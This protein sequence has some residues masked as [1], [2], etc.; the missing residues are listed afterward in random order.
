MEQSNGQV[1]PEDEITLKE[2]IL[3]VKEFYEEVIHYWWIIALC[4]VFTLGYF[5]FLAFT[6]PVKYE[7][8][9]TFMLNDE[10]G[11]GA[12]AGLLG[13]FGFGGSSG[14]SIN[15]EKMVELAQSRV[16]LNEVIFDEITIENRN[17]YLAN[18]IIRV[19]DLH[20]KWGKSENEKM[21]N[22]LFTHDDISAFDRTEG[23]AYKYILKLITKDLISTNIE[24]TGIVELK[25]TTEKES[26]SLHFTNELFDVLSSFYLDKSIEKQLATYKN[27]KSKTDSVATMLANAEYSLAAFQQKNRNLSLETAKLQEQRLA[28]AVLRL[29]TVYAE[30]LK[31]TEQTKFALDNATPFVQVIDRPLIPLKKVRKS[32][33]KAVL[34]GV[35]LGIFI[36]VLYIISRKIVRDA[37]N[38]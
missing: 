29:S 21:H 9:L 36:S 26:I 27:A 34:L 22:F 4:C 33:I 11:G 37:I 7:A 13:S 25:S 1:V 6:T 16:I 31:I 35:S 30:A 24:E 20:E 18:H 8:E 17:D 23:T 3:K 2:L 5:L 38:D 12:I 32:K 15:L 10:A 28:R 19:Y 14:Q